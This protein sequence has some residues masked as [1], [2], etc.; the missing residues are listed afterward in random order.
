M[1][2]GLRRRERRRSQEMA[3]GFVV[4]A[5]GAVGDA[6]VGLQGPVVRGERAGLLKIRERRLVI[7]AL[8]KDQAIVHEAASVVRAFGGHVA[9][10]RLLV[11]PYA[12]ALVSPGAESGEDGE[13][14]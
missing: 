13:R 3:F 9:P 8:H 14:A 2:V 1:G 7:A 12:I 10:E 11:E 4:A 6:E 5:Q